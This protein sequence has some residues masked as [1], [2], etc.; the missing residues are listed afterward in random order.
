MKVAAETK[1]EYGNHSRLLFR[2][3]CECHYR[4]MWYPL[5]ECAERQIAYHDEQNHETVTEGAG[6]ARRGTMAPAELVASRF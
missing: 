3:T 4:T 5:L 2:C 6:P 1:S